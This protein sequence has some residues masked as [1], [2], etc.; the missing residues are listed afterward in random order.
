MN[1]RLSAT[2]IGIILTRL[3]LAIVVSI[4][5]AA[6]LLAPKYTV[7]AGPQDGGPDGTLTTTSTG[8]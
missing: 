3:A 8:S 7:V 1:N 6:S 4:T 2:T 5:I